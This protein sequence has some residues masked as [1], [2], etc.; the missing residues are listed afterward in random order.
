MYGSSVF[1]A[2]LTYI[3]TIL[4]NMYAMVHHIAKDYAEAFIAKMLSTIHLP[5]N[6]IL[7]RRLLKATGQKSSPWYYNRSHSEMENDLF[8]VSEALKGLLSPRLYV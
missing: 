8:D 5:P 7:E 1:Y 6:P 4:T 2:P 3:R